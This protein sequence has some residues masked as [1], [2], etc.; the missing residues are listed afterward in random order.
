MREIKGERDMRVHGS[1]FTIKS[2]V[3][4]EILVTVSARLLVEV[5]TDRRGESKRY[6]DVY[7]DNHAAM[8]I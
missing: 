2:S 1:G 7:C 4:M 8:F 6:R 5:D 3:D